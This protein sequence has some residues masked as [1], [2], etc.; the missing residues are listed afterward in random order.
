MVGEKIQ[1]GIACETLQVSRSGFYSWLRRPSS[2]RTKE[3]DQLL[4]EIVKI[5]ADSRM[6]YGLPRICAKLKYLGRT[7][8]KNRVSRLMKKAGVSGLIRR[9][10]VVKTTD[11]KHNLPI[12]PRLFKTEEIE[13]H[14]TRPNECWASD[15]S[16][17]STD[18]GFVFLGTYLDIFTKKIVGFATDDHMR[19]S[20]LCQALEM[21]L[22]RSTSTAAALTSHSDRG[23]QYASEEYRECLKANNITASMSRKGN[24][25]DNAYAESFFGTL[26]KELIYR[27]HYRTRDEAKKAIFEY[28]EVWYNRER[29]HSSIGFMSP[30]QFEKLHAA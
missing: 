27:S 19:T 8:G 29:L 24:C 6:T 7:L 17:V 23:S 10:Y 12:A 28:I 3:N 4:V 18:E 13:T 5:H 20:L 25:Y 26:K 30:V 9:K 1:V 22:G 2:E 11:S 21:A 14:P 15:I 16:Y